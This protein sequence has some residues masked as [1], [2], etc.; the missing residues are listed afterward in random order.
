MKMS[1]FSVYDAQTE[2]YMRPWTAQTEGQATRIF[3]DE[4]QRPESEISKHPA[5][6]SLFVIGHFN[7]SSG[8]ITP[9]IP[10]KMLIQGHLTEQKPI[11]EEIKNA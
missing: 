10:N 11:L 5:D 6:Y 9:Q 4:L 8:E 2:A 3:T 7:D 1:I